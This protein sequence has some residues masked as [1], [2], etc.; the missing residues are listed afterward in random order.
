[1][2]P[3][4]PTEDLHCPTCGEDLKKWAALLDCP[5]GQPII[6]FGG[7]RIKY[8]YKGIMRDV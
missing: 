6:D 1:M 7:H 4:E 8:K 3:K 5:C 2:V